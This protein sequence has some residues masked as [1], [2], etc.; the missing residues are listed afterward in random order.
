[1]STVR[2]LV[3]GGIFAGIAVIFQT[4]PVIL[5]EL[6]LPV[7]VLSTFPVYFASRINPKAG[8]CTFISAAVIIF[9]ISLHEGFFFICTNGVMGLTLGICR[10]YTN[11]KLIITIITSLA[12][13]SS[14][15]LVNFIIG[16]PVFGSELPGLLWVQIILIW[17]FS[18]AYG[19][20]F[21]TISNFLFRRL[22]KYL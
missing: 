12:L 6:F 15:C 20:I 2:L 3:F 9:L 13:F 1:M 16:I 19:F 18:V 17:I 5:T 14:L 10:H 8:F 4:A 11:R 22:E 21:M 7:T